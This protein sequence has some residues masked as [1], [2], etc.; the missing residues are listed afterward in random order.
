MIVVTLYQW[1]LTKATDVTV[2]NYTY[3]LQ[4]SVTIIN[5]IFTTDCGECSN[6]Q[7][8]SL[9]FYFLSEM[10]GNVCIMINIFQN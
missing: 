1:S 10:T 9:S 6:H 8:L 4:W 7:S 2:I 5:D 3:N